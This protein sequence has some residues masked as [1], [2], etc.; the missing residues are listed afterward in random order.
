MGVLSHWLPW[1]AISFFTEAFGLQLLVLHVSVAS[2]D[3]GGL[4]ALG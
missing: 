2:Q 3:L 1:L 4:G